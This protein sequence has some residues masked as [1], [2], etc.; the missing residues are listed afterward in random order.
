MRQDERMRGDG[1]ES[2]KMESGG[3]FLMSQSDTLGGRLN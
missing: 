3:D 2:D 1:M